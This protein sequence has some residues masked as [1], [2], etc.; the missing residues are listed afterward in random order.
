MFDLDTFAALTS[1]TTLL[2]Y[3]GVGSAAGRA[4]GGATGRPRSRRQACP[5]W[6]YRAL[7]AC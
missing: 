7:R 2:A 1:L 5:S 6:L 3:P 4:L